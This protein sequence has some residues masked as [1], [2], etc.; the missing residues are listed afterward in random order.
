MSK[1]FNSKFIV[2]QGVIA[3]L[4]VLMTVVPPLSNLS[5]G[6]IQLRLSEALTLLA[7]FNGEY[8]WGLTIGCLFANIFSPFGVLDIVV[9]TFA[10]FL[11]AY[12]MSKCKNI[13]LSSIIPAIANILVGIQLYFIGVSKAGVLIVTGQIMVSEIIVVSLIGVPIFKMLI[14]NKV[15]VDYLKLNIKNKNLTINFK[16]MGK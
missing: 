9:G 15:L 3:A 4:Y 7:F 16:K 12:F 8:I 14:K 6:P 2:R 11:A 13:W 5:Y 1:K 10:S